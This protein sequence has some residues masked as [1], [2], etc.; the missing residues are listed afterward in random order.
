MPHPPLKILH[1]A[2][3]N[4]ANVPMTLVQAERE[5]GYYSRL[6]TFFRDPRGYEEDIV[7]DLPFITN[8]WMQQLKRLLSHPTRQ[9]V[10]NV[11]PQKTETPPVWKSGGRLENIL[12]ELREQLWKP[13]VSKFMRDIDFW[14][15]DIYCFEAGMDFFTDGRTVKKLHELGK[16]IVVLYTGSDLRTRGVFPVVDSLADFRATFE[17]DHLLLDQHLV[18]LPFPFD[19][20]KYPYNPAKPA[21]RLRIGHAPTNREAKGSDAILAVLHKLKQM[22][23]IEIVLIENL[24][25]TQALALKQSC[26]I[27]I[28]QIGDLG[29]GINSLEA[30]A[31]GIPTC[32]CLAPNFHQHFSEHPFVEIDS[33]NMEE[34]LV[35]LIE[36]PAKRL[37]LSREGRSWVEKYH[38]CRT[39]VNSIHSFCGFPV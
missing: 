16:N 5:Q 25:H 13:T 32:T 23:T 36:N 34:K 27:F 24:T 28:D 14:Q 35:Q 10:K 39:I 8:K 29:Y 7:L 6:V 17:L 20:M 15:F 19:T 22:F 4:I 21:E 9:A 30:L 12:I 18:H 11:L 38:D 31:F 33:S 1:I 3:Q 26:H 37:R 2:P